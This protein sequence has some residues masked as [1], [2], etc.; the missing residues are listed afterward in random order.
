MLVWNRGNAW[1]L[2]FNLYHEKYLGHAGLDEKR[3][4]PR[5][6]RKEIGERD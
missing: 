6:K 3:E 5:G 2:C 1:L 4:E